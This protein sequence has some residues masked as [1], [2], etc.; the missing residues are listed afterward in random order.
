MSKLKHYTARPQ[1]T[2]YKAKRFEG[3]TCYC[4]DCDKMTAHRAIC[5]WQ[6][7]NLTCGACGEVTSKVPRDPGAFPVEAAPTKKQL[8][9]DGCQVI[10][11]IRAIRILLSLQLRIPGS[12]SPV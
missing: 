6:W 8:H 12:T 4:P 9:E 3:L 2:Q 5:K 7:F 10:R 11:T 1:G